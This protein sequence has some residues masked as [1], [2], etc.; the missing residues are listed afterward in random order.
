MSGDPARRTPPGQ[1]LTTKWPVLTYG[2]APRFDPKTWSFR[3][4]GLVEQE[5]SWSWE[6]FLALPRAEVTT[7]ASR[8]CPFTRSRGASV[9]SPRRRTSV[10]ANLP[11]PFGERAG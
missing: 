1:V 5:I 11:L 6:E 8:A 10:P 9:S 7:T 4:F 3:C 2:M